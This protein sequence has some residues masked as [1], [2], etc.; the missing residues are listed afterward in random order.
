MFG[1]ERILAL[2]RENAHK[3]AEGIRVEIME[4]VANYQSNGQED[5]IA[6]VVIKKL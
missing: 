5:D 3:S 4:A 1:K 6:V 2:V